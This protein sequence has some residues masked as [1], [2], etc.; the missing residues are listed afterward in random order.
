[1][2]KTKALAKQ[3]GMP[4]SKCCVSK[5]RCKRCPIRMLAEGTLPE[6]CTVR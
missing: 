6:G 5:D 3:K 4:K 1:V 2:G